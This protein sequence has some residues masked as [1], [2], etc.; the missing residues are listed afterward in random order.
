MSQAAP[1]FLG[2]SDQPNDMRR[3]GTEA[4][5]DPSVPDPSTQD[6]VPLNVRQYLSFAPK[7]TTWPD[8]Q[9]VS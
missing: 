4:D 1:R 7:W 2:S 8:Y 6:P 3:Y 5:Q 9:R